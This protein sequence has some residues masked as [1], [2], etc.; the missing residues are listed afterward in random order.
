[1]FRRQ[2]SYTVENVAISEHSIHP[3]ACS[4]NYAKSISQSPRLHSSQTAHSN[5]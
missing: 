5:P 3:I 1:M 4:F 2:L